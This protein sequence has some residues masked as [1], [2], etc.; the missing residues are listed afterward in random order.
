MTDKVSATKTPPIK[1][2]KTSFLF[3]GAGGIDII[4]LGE[5]SLFLTCAGGVTFIFSL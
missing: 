3:K 4:F 5:K 1:S 2:N